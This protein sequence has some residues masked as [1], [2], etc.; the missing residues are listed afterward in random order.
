MEIISEASAADTRSPMTGG[1]AMDGDEAGERVVAGG[2]ALSKE[3]NLEKH[4]RLTNEALARRALL[5]ERD[6][7]EGEGEKDVPVVNVDDVWKVMG[8]TTKS[9]AVRALS[10]DKTM[11]KG[12]I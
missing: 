1:S 2:M 6:G 3:T 9:D 10:R 8:Y 5:L 7:R 4:Q 12:M 11:V